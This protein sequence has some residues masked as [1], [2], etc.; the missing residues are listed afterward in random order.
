MTIHETSSTTAR[1]DW[2]T[3]LRLP[4]Q[5]AAPEGPV[6]MHTMYVM[7]H[8]FRRD[9]TAFAKAAE[10]TP[11]ADRGTWQALSRRWQLFS[12]VLHH[13][14][15]GE[16]A[17][18]WPRLMEAADAEGRATLEAME[19]EHE[20]IDPLLEACA[21]GFGRLAER[22]DDD[23]RA[24][25]AVRLVATRERL[26]R[27]LEHEER[28]A[29][30]LVQRHLT[31]ADWQALEEEHFRADLSPRDL[32]AIVPWAAHGIPAETRRL[33][34]AR[35]GLP[36]RVLWRLGRRSFERRERAAFRFVTG[37]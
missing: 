2:P 11:S 8:A 29:I 27:H 35:T 34:L 26:A 18:L 28:D 12:T 22:D 7:H 21:Q 31:E 30:A 10:A 9:L 23:A 3:Q 25:L 24:A 17:G 20:E 5:A 6:D 4:G 19:A 1:A 32:L 33:V 15:S 36:F 37:A 13:H 16:D 14:H